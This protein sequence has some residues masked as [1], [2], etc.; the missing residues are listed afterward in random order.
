MRTFMQSLALAIG[1]VL[2]GGA[3]ADTPVVDDRGVAAE[4]L[5]QAKL[6]LGE[7]S[8]R[9]AELAAKLGGDEARVRMFR[10]VGNPDRPVIGVVLGESDKR[11]VRIEGVTPGGPADKAGLRA[12]DTITSISGSALAGDHPVKRL[13]QALADLKVGDSVPVTYERNGSAF[14]GQIVAKAQGLMGFGSGPQMFTFNSGD[15]DELKNLEHLG[16]EIERQV[17]RM[18]QGSLGEM[19][20]GF[21]VMTLASMSGLRLTSM[22]KGLG[23]YFG[24]DSG[25]LVLEV[26]S[27]E[28]K[29]LQ[30]GDVILEV[31]G[32]A[33]KDPRETLR[34]LRKFEP[35]QKVELKLQRDRVPQLVKVSVPEKSRAFLMPPPPTPPAP[36]A[37]PRAPTPPA[38][39]AAPAPMAM[40]HTLAAPSIHAAPIPVA[41]PHAPLAPSPPP[42]PVAPTP[43]APPAPPALPSMRIV[44]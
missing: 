5:R 34:A 21:N 35:E 44:I 18:V 24:V 41:A 11:G 10:S 25:A 38:P 31:D 9:V 22:N 19:G 3:S 13:R 20:P 4:E 32:Q 7:A 29:G 43:P 16:P 6:E 28:Y 14:K 33:V 42:A 12:G 2:A 37:P 15:F 26:E 1:L 39:P 36:P 8:R 23:R 27:D 30:A 17:E 40:P